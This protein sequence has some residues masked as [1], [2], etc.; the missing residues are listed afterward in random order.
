ML[1]MIGERAGECIA[2]PC[3]VGNICHC[4]GCKQILIILSGDLLDSGWLGHGW[5]GVF[6]DFFHNIHCMFNKVC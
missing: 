1:A 4:I 3:L 5:N 2:V 6:Q